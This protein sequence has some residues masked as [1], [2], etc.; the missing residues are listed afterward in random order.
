VLRERLGLDGAS[1]TIDAID[2]ATA[3]LVIGCDLN[4][5]ATGMNIGSNKGGHQERR[6]LVVANSVR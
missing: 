1:A 5:E 2:R 3:I 6:A 4:A